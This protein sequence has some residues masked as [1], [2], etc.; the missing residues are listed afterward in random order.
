MARL[1]GSHFT[2]ERGWVGT[3]GRRDS[4]ADDGDSPRPRKGPSSDDI[5]ASVGGICCSPSPPD[6]HTSV[7]LIVASMK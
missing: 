3:W 2:R 4:L 5:A 7:R 1:R 6:V